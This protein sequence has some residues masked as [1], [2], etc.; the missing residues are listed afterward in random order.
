MTRRTLVNLPRY[1]LGSASSRSWYIRLT[2]SM[3]TSKM[4]K[5]MMMP[6][7][8]T[9]IIRPWSVPRG[10]NYW[11]AQRSPLNV[12]QERRLLR[13]IRM[14]RINQQIW[15]VMPTPVL[16][17]IMPSLSKYTQQE[18]KCDWILSITWKCQGPRSCLSSSSLWLAQDR[19]NNY[20]DHASSSECT[21]NE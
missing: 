13:H 2:L 17:E 3:K 9:S 14:Q 19:R 16:L 12:L 8:E 18:S 7:I 21:Y 11:C 1:L 4:L 6:V 5:M 20:L 15:I 10:G